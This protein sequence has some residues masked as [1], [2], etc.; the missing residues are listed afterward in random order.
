MKPYYIISVVLSILALIIVAVLFFPSLS[1]SGG[2]NVYSLAGYFDA[3][4]LLMVALLFNSTIASLV[5]WRY[6]YEGYARP[7]S[8][9]HFVLVAGLALLAFDATKDK[10]APD[11]YQLLSKAATAGD[12][13]SVV[14]ILNK[15]AVSKELRLKI[16]TYNVKKPAIL[17]LFLQDDPS[18]LHPLFCYAVDSGE[19]THVKHY[20]KRGADLGAICSRFGVKPAFLV[21]NGAILRSLLQAGLR[22]EETNKRSDTAFI[23]LIYVAQLEDELTESDLIFAVKN[24]PEIAKISSDDGSNPLMLAIRGGY[25]DL[26]QV[27]VDSGANVNQATTTGETA[28]FLAE[29]ALSVKF[30]LQNGA[31]LNHQNSM[32]KT[33][34]SFIVSRG[35]GEAAIEL[36]KSGADITVKDHSGYTVVDYI[37]RPTN[38]MSM[39]VVMRI[40]SIIAQK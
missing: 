26:A 17:D 31:N 5:F 25:L 11:I 6:G 1:N 40:E 27:L 20:I 4:L 13:P 14:D 30:L 29:T 18:L 37:Q 7:V 12:G 15:G 23:K 10:P 35:K 33:P 36:I 24:Q 16:A 19:Y 21:Q 2:G 22:L 34:L 28:M 3:A 32:G 39:E 9:A 8:I 38:E